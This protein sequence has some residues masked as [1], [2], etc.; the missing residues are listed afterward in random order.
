MPVV[1]RRVDVDRLLRRQAAA[2]ERVRQHVEHLD[3]G[4][5]LGTSLGREV[6]DT[7]HEAGVAGK[8][9]QS[10][11]V[12][13]RVLLDQAAA[14]QGSAAVPDAVGIHRENHGIAG[15]GTRLARPAWYD[16]AGAQ[17]GGHHKRG[18]D[19]QD[20]ATAA[21]RVTSHAVCLRRR[22]Q[23]IKTIL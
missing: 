12:G 4:D 1:V 21:P 6:A 10:L 14:G 9:G 3:A 19:R 15:S 13:Q 23:K 2:G 17:D 7:V 16:R 18:D 20:D 8:G 22:A 5:R 11:E